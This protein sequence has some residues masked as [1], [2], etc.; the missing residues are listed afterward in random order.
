MS[1]G[2]RT[3]VKKLGGERTAAVLGVDSD[4][5]RIE[6]NQIHMWGPEMSMRVHYLDYQTI[7]NIR[8]SHNSE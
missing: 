6:V 5:T 2:T 4:A 7:T 3:E 1:T 8:D